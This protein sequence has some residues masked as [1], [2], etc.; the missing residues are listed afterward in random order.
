MEYTV[1]QV[2]WLDFEWETEDSNMNVHNR[3]NM[4]Q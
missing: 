1:I 4:L 2:H 3:N